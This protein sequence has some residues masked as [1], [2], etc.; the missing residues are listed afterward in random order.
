MGNFS[1]STGFRIVPKKIP[2]RVERGFNFVTPEIQ[3]SNHFLQDLKKLAY[4]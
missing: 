1:S 2:F 3:I 4:F